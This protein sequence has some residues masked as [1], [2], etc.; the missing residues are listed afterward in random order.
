MGV[1]QAWLGAMP[2]EGF[3][4]DHLGR[5]PFA[6]PD[7]AHVEAARCDWR[8]VDELLAS[9][10]ADTLVVRRGE[11]LTVEV[12]RSLQQLR[13]LFAR[14]AGVA[15]RRADA[16]SP[17]VGALA[18]SVG[19]DV[20]GALRVI[21]FATPCNSSGFGWHFDEEEV[22]ILQ[23]GGTKSYF[24]RAN[25]V[26]PRPLRALPAA[27]DDYRRETSPMLTARLEPGD[28]LYLPSGYWHAAYAHDDSLSVSIGVVSRSA[29]AA[30][31]ALDAA[32]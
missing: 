31:P 17:C 16:A 7:V 27:F 23:T 19:D 26:S 29:L 10:H 22:F 5:L 28:W 20:A 12:P 24:F 9:E 15:V 32:R 18:R 14:G 11:V 1:L 3:R 6:A 8:I 4:A 30:L 2:L 21:V 13:T 25:T